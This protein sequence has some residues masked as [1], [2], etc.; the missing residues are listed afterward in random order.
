MLTDEV[1]G[2]HRQPH[3][4]PVRGTRP[5]GPGRAAER[6]QTAAGGPAP[7]AHRLRQASDELYARSPGRPG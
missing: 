1:R 6:E 4:V 5:A 2:P 7:A 3:E